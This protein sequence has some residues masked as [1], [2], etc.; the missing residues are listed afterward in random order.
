ME[1]ET[2]GCI[3]SY[4]AHLIKFKDQLS[5]DGSSSA[6]KKHSTPSI[7]RQRFSTMFNEAESKF[8]S[9][10]KIDLLV[11]YVLVLCLFVDDFKTD[12]TD[13]AKDLRMSSVKLREH[14]LNLGCTFSRQKGTLYAILPAPLKFP[15]AARRRRR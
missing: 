11:S 2:I 3:L 9:A 10:E 13:I 14:F 7:L 1:K 4:I 12:P 5:A 6:K 8:L 15:E